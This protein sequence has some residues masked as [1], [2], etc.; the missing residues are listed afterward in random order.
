MKKLILSL[1]LALSFVGAGQAFAYD[2][3]GK[4]NVKEA[5]GGSV[6]DP[7][8]VYTLVRYAEIAANDPALSAGE[9]V[10][11]DTVSDDGVTVGKIGDAGSSDAVAGVVVSTTIPTA[12]ATGTAVESIGRRNWGY[13][14]TYGLCTKAMVKGTIAAGQALVADDVNSGYAAGIPNGTLSRSGS[15]FGFAYDASSASANDAE[16]FIKNR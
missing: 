1:F 5:S 8:R 4:V 3:G 16:I 12:D 13:I 11:W 14:Q 7:V 9:V 2:E 10:A 15:I 6:A